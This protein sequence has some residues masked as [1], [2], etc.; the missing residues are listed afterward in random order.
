M[1]DSEPYGT[2]K[3]IEE[4]VLVNWIAPARPF[5]RRS[6]DFYITILA[7]ASLFGLVIFFIEGF[8]PILLMISLIFLFYVMSTVEPENIEY[9]ITNLGV[10]V[11]GNTTSWELMGRFWFARRFGSELLVIEIA[12]LPGRM[13]IVVTPE[14][15][16]QV[17]A[18]LEK[19]LTH[20][21]IPPSRLDRMTGWF[22]KKLPN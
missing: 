17:K 10:K 2:F 3:K 12:R 4:K 16:E 20:E 5:K 7:M 18:E 15:K 11:A 1:P 8:M 14:V 6:R 13:E 19:K 9:Q 22:S 21:A